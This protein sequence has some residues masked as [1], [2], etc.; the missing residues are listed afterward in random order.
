MTFSPE[1]EGE[2]ASL[3]SLN[4]TYMPDRVYDLINAMHADLYHGPAVAGHLWEEAAI[5]HKVS[6]FPD[7]TH[8][9]RD[10]LTENIDDVYVDDPSDEG[11]VNGDDWAPL[12]RV[13]GSREEIIRRLVGQALYLYVI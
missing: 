5:A 6:N 12:V 9:V 4:R 1:I 7:A 11:G 2:I 3:V 13:E 8:V 10:W